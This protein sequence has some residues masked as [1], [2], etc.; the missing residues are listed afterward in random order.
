MSN[1]QLDLFDQLVVIQGQS[2]FRREVQ[3]TGPAGQELVELAFSH[4]EENA[5][6]RG[7][8]PRITDIIAGIV[9]EAIDDV[10][11]EGVLVDVGEIVEEAT[12]RCE[13][14]VEAAYKRM[15]WRG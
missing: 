15:R 8:P 5:S 3:P 6:Y 13:A 4:F 11:E 14:E 9:W 2:R 10:V 12:S 7:A 1:Q